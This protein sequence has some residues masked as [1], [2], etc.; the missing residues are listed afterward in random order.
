MVISGKDTVKCTQCAFSEPLE[1]L[2]QE[3]AVK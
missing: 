1:K 3:A 2:E